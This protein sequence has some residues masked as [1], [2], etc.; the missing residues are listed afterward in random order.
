MRRKRGGVRRRWHSLSLLTL[1]GC[2]SGAAPER[3][4]PSCWQESS[5]SG[6]S[7]AW[8]L[9]G[10]PEL[11]SDGR[12]AALRVDGASD[13]L[14][15]RVSDPAGGPACLQLDS[16]LESDGSAWVSSGAGDLGPY[17]LSCPQRVSVGVGYGLFVLPSNDQPLQFPTTLDV[18]AGVRDCATLLPTAESGLGRVRI[19][20]LGAAT[21]EATRLG[22]ISL[23]LAF[24]EASPLADEAQR[25]AVL[26]ETL[27]LV[28]ALL[29]PGA[30]QVSVARTRTVA[31]PA[32]TLELIRGDNG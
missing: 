23:G 8:R 3:G 28:N 29:A 32:R 15:L 21:V 10:E 26:P 18:V 25:E 30:L 11:G 2:G 9:L 20:A 14:A 12:S 27:R 5:A 4:A 7:L 17:C 13:G 6:P 31:D 16:V 19:E 1:V 22:V 24:L